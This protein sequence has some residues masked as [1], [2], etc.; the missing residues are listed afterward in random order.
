MWMGVEMEDVDEWVGVE[1]VDVDGWVGVEMSGWI[2][3]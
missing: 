3:G 1:I 2:G